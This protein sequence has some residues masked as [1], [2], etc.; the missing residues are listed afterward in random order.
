[1]ADTMHS[2]GFIAVYPIPSITEMDIVFKGGV[3]VLDRISDPGNMGT[4]IRSA[5]AFGSS[6][7]IAGSGSCCPFAPKVTRAAAGTNTSFPI[8]FDVDLAS[9][10]RR[11]SSECCFIGADTSG[12]TPERLRERDRCIGLV[13]GSE[14]QGIS[15]TVSHLL[16]D[17]VGI[18]MVN[19]VE[20]LNA[21]VSASILLWE[22][23]R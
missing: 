13:I 21:G 9:F 22:M 17:S 16:E 19:D 7:L 18:P 14:S 10:I 11:H 15:E 23:F 5:S 6:A 8:L 2:Q 12:G 1:M 3:L 4:M 20:S